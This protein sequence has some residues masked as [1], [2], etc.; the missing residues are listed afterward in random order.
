MAEQKEL[1]HKKIFLVFIP[2]LLLGSLALFIQIIRYQ[3]LYPDPITPPT[4]EDDRPFIIKLNPDDPVL[5]NKR[6]PHT[7]VAFEDFSCGN[8]LTQHRLFTS[9]QAQYPDKVKIIWKGLPVQEFPYSS[10]DSIRYGYCAAEQNKF[11]EFASYAFENYTNLVIETLDIISEEVALD[12]TDLAE[13]LS[14]TR[15]NQWVQ[16]TKQIAQTLNVR[17]VPTFFINN[18]QIKTPGSIEE[19][20]QLFNL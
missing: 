10:L 2:A 11:N 1:T 13:C 6:A 5:G 3:P 17:S 4:T 15:P 16:D 14:S 19:W 18:I 12:E 9:L 7:I 8:C 20:K